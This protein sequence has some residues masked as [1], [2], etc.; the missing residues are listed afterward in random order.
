MCKTD[1]HF[2]EDEIDRGFRGLGRSSAIFL[3]TSSQAGMAAA[4]ITNSLLI[5]LHHEVIEFGMAFEPGL[6]ERAIDFYGQVICAGVVECEL[7][8][9]RSDAAAADFVRDFGVHEDDPAVGKAIFERSHFAID[10][11]LELLSFLV[12]KNSE[13]FHI[14]LPIQFMQFSEYGAFVEFPR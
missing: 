10:Q 7:R 9:C 14:V 1:V 8:Q 12:V 3:Y 2:F 5:S 11:D 13:L 6:Y 4:I